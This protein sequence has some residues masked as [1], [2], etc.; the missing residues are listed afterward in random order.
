MINGPDARKLC[1]RIPDHQE[2]PSTPI[3]IPERLRSQN[4][5]RIQPAAIRVPTQCGW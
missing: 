1:E 3:S 4:P 2:A 5:L